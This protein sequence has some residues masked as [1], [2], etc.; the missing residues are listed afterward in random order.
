MFLQREEELTRLNHSFNLPNSSLDFIFGPKSSGKTSLI[1]EYVKDKDKLYFSNYEM[2]PSLFFTKMAN[3]INSYFNNSD[4]NFTFN[5][6]TDV[7]K[8][9]E[10][11]VIKSKL[12]I[13][14]DDFHSIIK[15]EKNSLDILFK[16]WKNS[17]KNKNIHIIISS[18]LLFSNSYKKDIQKIST[19]IIHLNYLDF[20]VIKEFFPEMKRIDQLYIYSLLGTSPSNLKYYNPKTDFSENIFNLFLSTNSF[21]FDYGIKVLKSEITDIGTYSSI[22][23]SISIGN[24]KIGDIANS[25]DIKSSYLSRYIQKLID[26]MIIKKNVPVGD[27]EQTSKF[28]RYEIRDSTLKFWFS[29]IF[30]NLSSLQLNNIKEVSKIIEDEFIRKTVFLSYKKCIIEFIN[31]NKKNILG[32]EP[33]AIDSWWD[34]NNTHIDLIAYDKKTVTFIQILWENKEIAKISYGELKSNSNKFKTALNKKYIII[35]KDTFFNIN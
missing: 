7:L 3:S 29:Y 1:N 23:Y 6:L 34:N 9:L 26:M 8:F 16:F 31:A 25:L 14:L 10:I 22:L 27:N 2:I 15:V 5:S 12:V 19:N 32:Y 30:P 20:V 28:G 13:I 33:V 11:Q 18:S 21:L 24:N 35:T 4:I 17:L